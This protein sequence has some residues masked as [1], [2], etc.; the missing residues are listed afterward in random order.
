MFLVLKACS[1]LG[2]FLLLPMMQEFSV[3]TCMKKNPG[4]FSN[5]IILLPE[6][7]PVISFYTN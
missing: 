4:R 6:R 1:L 2:I 3:K 7:K 5:W